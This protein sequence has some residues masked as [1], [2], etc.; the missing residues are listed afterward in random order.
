MSAPD[1]ALLSALAAE[2]ADMRARLDGV[3]DLVS[4]VVRGLPEAERQAALAPAQA[5]DL[6]GQ[7]LDVLTLMLEGLS[8]GRN[9]ADLVAAVTLSDMAARLGA[10]AAVPPPGGVAAG[11]LQ[12]F[13]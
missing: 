8:S 10:G 7:R 3:A 2:T 12:L 9:P 11:D 13:E 6:M 4:A 1:R 5:L